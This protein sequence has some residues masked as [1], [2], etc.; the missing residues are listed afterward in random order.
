M[1]IVVLSDTH[2]APGSRRRLPDEVYSALDH[3]DAIIHA[4]DIVTAELVYELQGFAPVHAV[5]GNND[6]GQLA[7]MLP[8]TFVHDFDGVRVGA[9]HDSGP[10]EGRA[11]R[12]RRR[13]P[14]A[15]VVVFGHSHIPFCD[16]HLEGQLLFNP[17]S[18]TDKRREPVPTYGLLQVDGGQV[19]RAGV[20]PV[21]G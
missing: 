5:L 20:I 14:D 2:M 16:T 13:F 17:G 21:A 3:A 11:G 7:G 8:E 4:G 9:I 15:D 19:V 1:R 18:P 6:D 10:R 12:M